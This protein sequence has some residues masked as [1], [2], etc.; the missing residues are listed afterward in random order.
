MA[1]KHYPQI[2]NEDI[3]SMNIENVNAYLRD[4]SISDDKEKPMTSGLFKLKAGQSL[5]YTTLTMK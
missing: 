4:F 1:F 3:P 5:K 2:I